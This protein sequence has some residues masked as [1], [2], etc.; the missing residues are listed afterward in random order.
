VPKELLRSALGC[1]G[2]AAA[3]DACPPPF[4]TSPSATMLEKLSSEK[5]SSFRAISFVF[6]DLVH[7]GNQE[8]LPFAFFAFV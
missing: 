2:A 5:L 1:S 3:V 6:V 7:H 4:R 8:P